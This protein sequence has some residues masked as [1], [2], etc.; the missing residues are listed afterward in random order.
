MFR[1]L[2]N[3]RILEKKGLKLTLGLSAMSGFSLIICEGL[4]LGMIKDENELELGNFL[5]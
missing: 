2:W 4:K 1:N 3:I 5:F